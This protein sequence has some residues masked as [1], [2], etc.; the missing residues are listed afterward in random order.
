MRPPTLPPIIAPSG[1]WKEEDGEEDADDSKEGEEIIFVD[2]NDDD[3]VECERAEL[4]LELDAEG[5][6]MEGLPS[7]IKIYV[8][9]S[10]VDEPSPR[11]VT[12]SS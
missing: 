3:A 10:G 7:W 5:A 9:V 6:E 8:T 2:T 4:E 11:N 12:T 1:T